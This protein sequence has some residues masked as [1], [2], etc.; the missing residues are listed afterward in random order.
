MGNLGDKNFWKKNYG[1]LPMHLVPQNGEERFLMLNGGTSDFCFQSFESDDS[2]ETYFQSSWSTNTKN[3]L[4][5]GE[6]KLKI[7]NWY[8]NSV[9]E[10]SKTQVLS[11]S[12]KF[13]EYLL[14]KSFKTQ[15]D[16]VPFIIDIFRQLRNLTLEKENAKEALNLLYL[17]LVSIEEDFSTIKFED[18]GFNVENIPDRFEYFVETIRSGIKS[19]KPNLDLI[20]RHTS[21]ALFQEAHREVIYFSPQRDL[22]GGVSSKLIT[23]TDSYSSIHYTPQYI[24]RSIV[25]NCLKEIDIE[26]NELIILDPAC[27]SS[28]FLIEVLKQLR[29][30]DYKGRV[31]IKGF[32][33]S[34]SAIN[35]SRF[36]LEYENRTQWQNN[37]SIDLK[38]VEDSLSENWGQNNDIVLMNP[39]FVSWE[40]IK[41]KESRTIILDT[42]SESFKKGKP[43][44]ASAFFYKAK[45]ALAGSGILGCVLPSS[46]LQRESYSSLRNE[47]QEE[48]TIKLIAKLGN[49][50]FED[51]LT[52]VSLFIGKKPKSALTPKVIWAKNEK[53]A[54]QEALRELRKSTENNEL[55]IDEK[56]YSIYTPTSFPFVKDSWNI[57][58]LKE[59][60]FIKNTERFIL[61]NKLVHISKIFTVKQGI[62]SGN[63]NAFIISKEV[64]DSI[65]EAEKHLYRKVIGNDSIKNGVI[66]LKNYIWYPYDEEKSLFQSE[67]EL[68]DFAPYSY[69]RLLEYK[70]VLTN[71]PRNSEVNWWLLSEHRAWLRKKEKR[72]FSTE[73][74]KS[75][76]F[77][78]DNVGDFVVERGNAWSSK[79]AMSDDDFFFY[80]SV[81]SSGIFDNFLSI[82]SK[83]I[84][85][86]Y[87]LGQTYTKD[88]PIPNI[89]T[90]DKK[91][92]EYVKLVE[93]GKELSK[94]NSLAKYSI[95]EILTTYFYP[96]F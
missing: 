71:R 80:L 68:L 14:L 37:L 77:G 92:E 74:G 93:L 21:G 30:L 75:D 46:I 96:K 44:Q 42:L 38:L 79:R 91:S 70:N 51:A 76:S 35:T 60:N 86:G 19:I 25:E 29:E 24:A 31:S 55:S 47:F 20:L 17:L 45:G 2:F 22:F 7:F 65:P 6:D 58:S 83:P 73:F 52:D 62:R 41:N 15:N 72:L 61:D 94:G 3:Y 56:K 85:S 82:F 63:N 81:F 66:T 28:E 1:L 26:K 8:N 34:E 43:N 57:I 11:N 4:I 49:F 64:F 32:D 16:V 54:V 50:V 5:L 36:L 12:E 88:I 18:W 67:G 33:I 95:D 89:Y 39:P 23:K 84:M 78:F 40:L 53:G 27:G 90:L 69:F 59:N 9:E 13:Y 10:V 87:Y 48:L